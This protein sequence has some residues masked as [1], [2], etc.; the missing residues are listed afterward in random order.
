MVLLIRGHTVCRL[1]G[2]VIEKN[3]PVVG[4]PPLVSNELDPLYLFNDAAFHQECFY[5][6]PLSSKVQW[7]CLQYETRCGPGKRKCAVCGEEVTNPDEYEG[8]GYF[9]DDPEHPLYR[10]NFLHMHRACIRN[11]EDAAYLCQLLRSLIDSGQMKG[12]GIDYLLEVLESET[13]TLSEDH[14]DG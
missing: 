1:C 10:F 6:H 11:W 9:T 12:R 4:F 2:R 14:T 5:Q 3:D 8:L 13:K 7:L